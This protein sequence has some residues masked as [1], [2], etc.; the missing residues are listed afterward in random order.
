VL[1]PGVM[2]RALWNELVLDL[3]RREAGGLAHADGPVHVHRVA[4]AA[5]PVENQRERRDGADVD[6]GLAHLGHVQIRLERDLLVAGR[7]AAEI[8]RREARRL[9]HAG[10]QRIE[11]QRRSHG[12]RP[13][14]QR[15][16]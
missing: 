4:V 16:E 12:H 5:R 1:D 2:V 14:D 9:G 15:A 6:G 3:D 8:A 10:H 7:A 13:L 11:D